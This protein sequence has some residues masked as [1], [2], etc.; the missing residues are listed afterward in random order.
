MNIKLNRINKYYYDQGKST[1]ALENINLEFNTDGSFV[2]IT[3]ESGAGKSSLIKV[4]TGLEDYDEGEMYFDNIPVSSLSDK[5]KQRIYSDN[6]SFVFQDY[7]LVESISCIQNIV[8]AL[9]KQGK[10][11][12]EAKELAVKALLDV[13]LKKQKNM[14]VSKLSGGE[15]QRVAIARSLA[16]NTPIIV[17]DE[18][19]GNLDNQTSKQIIDIISKISSN[20]LILY[21]THDYEIVKKQ[22]TRHIVLADSNVI[23]D[24]RLNTP[25]SIEEPQKTRLLDNKFGFFSYFY[26]TYL[27][28][29]KHVGRTIATFLVLLFCFANI[30]GSF[31]IFGTSVTAIGSI[32][33]LLSLNYSNDS[34]TYSMGN[35]I[36]NSKTTTEEENVIYQGDYYLD[37][38]DILSS[39]VRIYSEDF[40][41]EGDSSYIDEYY[42]YQ[43]CFG[44]NDVL[45]L[46]YFVDESELIKSTQGDGISIYIPDNWSQNGYYYETLEEIYNKEI[47]ISSDTWYDLK[48]AY[49]CEVCESA[50]DDLQEQQLKTKITSIYKYDSTTNDTSAIYLTMSIDK[51]NAVRE[52]ILNESSY[53]SL[54]SNYYISPQYEDSLLI[55]DENGDDI[56][57]A[58]LD[59]A[60]DLD[61][62]NSNRLCLSENL[63][64]EELTVKY[65]NLELPLDYFNVSYNLYSDDNYSICESY[66]N[67][68]LAENE[69][70][71]TAYFSDIETAIT[72]YENLKESNSRMYYQ[73]YQTSIN[74]YKLNLQSENYVVNQVYLIIFCFILLN[75]LITA[76][77]IRFIINRFYYRKTYDQ[78]VLS[79][80]GFSFKNIVVI[81]LLQ[82]LVL[83][84]ISIGVVYTLMAVLIPYAGALFSA[85]IGLLLISIIISLMCSVFFGLPTRKKVREND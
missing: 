54:F 49:G 52:S 53:V 56:S 55:S 81:N 26:S 67:Q 27:I 34:P 63:E 16:L 65:K 77:L 18:P 25:E 21:V 28:G 15:R 47:Y 61:T 33:D 80:I 69:L 35:V 83:G 51:L 39:S 59:T 24:E 13:D 32:G 17:F 78:Q 9:I 57:F 41:K 79:Y 70:I 7:N 5:K 30:F 71:S 46:P 74:S 45:A 38:G 62:L 29:F 1:K 6:I 50:A 40:Q 66:M 10:T 36:K 68:V 85:N 42:Y 37:Y 76:I 2:V 73:E 14:R 12:R 20:K 22:A 72:N 8:L 43:S 31:Y 84:V 48:N 82:F 11:R 60:S 3:G 64:G 75:Q 4:I 19:T 23:K 58:R 44:N